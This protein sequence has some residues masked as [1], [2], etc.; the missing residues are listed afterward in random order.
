MLEIQTELRRLGYYKGALDGIAGPL[1]RK[2]ARAF[3][4][5]GD[6]PPDGLL[7]G[8]LLGSLKSAPLTLTP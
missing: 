5:D 8:K 2:A 3:R 7:D 4:R 1:T 6:L